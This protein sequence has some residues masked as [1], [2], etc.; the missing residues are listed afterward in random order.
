MISFSDE[1]CRTCNHWP[2]S[3]RNDSRKPYG[4]C[5]TP[6]CG[7]EQ[8]DDGTAPPEEPAPAVELPR[9]D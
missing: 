2:K 5:R 6:Y 3:H 8:F 7:C 4:R 9:E 1:R